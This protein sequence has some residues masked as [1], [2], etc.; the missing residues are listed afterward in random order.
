MKKLLAFFSMA[1]VLLGA[2]GC[3]K[4]G[5][6]M[7][8]A[9]FVAADVET[10]V[11]IRGYVAAKQSWWDDKATL[12]LLDDDGG[13]FVYNLPCTEDQYKTDLAVGKCVK[14][15]GQKINFSG[16]I[17]ILGDAA[18]AEAIYEVD[19]KAKEFTPVATD[20]SGKLG[21]ANLVDYQND[22][23]TMKNLT[24]L[25]Y[26]N[27]VAFEYKEGTP[28]EDIYFKLSDGTNTLSCCIESYLTGKDTAVYK[29]VEA[30]E[31]D[32]TVTIEGFL[33]WY[34]GANPHVTKLTVNA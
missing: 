27:G 22:F 29:A 7:T 23:F 19:K 9:E 16:E 25:E 8:H 30:L 11:V 2:V 20:L 12:Y 13:Y 18:G 3:S 34:N 26:S 28:G 4:I 14:I 1:F 15:K 33:Y 6:P 5:T 32:Q 10:V 17:E 31:I 24:V 21:D